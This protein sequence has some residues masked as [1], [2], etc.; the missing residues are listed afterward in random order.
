[1]RSVPSVRPA[2]RA[3]PS[4][5]RS[6]RPSAAR[7][8]AGSFTAPAGTATPNSR[9]RPRTRLIAAVLCLELL[10]HPVQRLHPLLPR[11]LHRHWSIWRSVRPRSGR[12]HRRGRSCCVARVERHEPAAA[13]PAC[14]CAREAARP[15]ARAA[16]G[17]HHHLQGRAIVEAVREAVTGQPLALQGH[18]PAPSAQPVE[19][20]FCRS[21]AT[22]VACV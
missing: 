12:R 4:A 15:V 10:A 2:W 3:A 21:M 17:L 1:M 14:P 5:R 13:A 8:A 22:T 18:G 9:S 6:R 7:T 16:A 11:R 20:F 19:Y